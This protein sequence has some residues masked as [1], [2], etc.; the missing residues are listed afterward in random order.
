MKTADLSTVSLGRQTFCFKINHKE[1]FIG[2][3]RIKQYTPCGEGVSLH[4][5][6]RKQQRFHN[7]SHKRM[8]Q[9]QA[10]FSR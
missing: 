4:N 9:E 10:M 6:V 5:M 8:Q 1:L 3:L 7:I 2:R